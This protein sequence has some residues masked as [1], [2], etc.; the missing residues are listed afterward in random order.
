MKSTAIVCAIAAAT[1]G[2][3]SLSFAQDQRGPGRDRDQRYE[4]RGPQDRDGRGFDNRNNDQFGR[5]DNDRRGGPRGFE[6]RHDGH[7]DFDRRDARN[8]RGFRHYNAR[9]PEF[10]RGGYVPPQYRAQQY[11]VNDWRGHRLSAPP[12]GQQWVQVGSDYVLIALATGI[13]ASMVLNS[14]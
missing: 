2:F 10:R 4:Q 13:I 12:R 3:S 9:G 5:R 6:Q 11:Y 1:L 14:N 8:D 7:R